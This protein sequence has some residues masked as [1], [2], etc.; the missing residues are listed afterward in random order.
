MTQYHIPGREKGK[1]LPDLFLLAKT[2][3]Q[4]CD[5][6]K[7]W[8]LRGLVLCR[9]NGNVMCRMLA[10]RKQ[11]RG[12]LWVMNCFRERLHGRIAVPVGRSP[13]S[14][15]YAVADNTA[16]GCFSEA[17]DVGLAPHS[18]HCGWWR[19]SWNILAVLLPIY[20]HAT[21]RRGV[22]MMTAYCAC[23]IACL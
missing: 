23:P 5:W 15:C 4:V 20:R 12:Y 18:S 1:R 8:H 6:S 22:W 9:G 16:I 7:R 21:C 17:Y 3:D 19:P 10:F 13:L 14:P 11:C 2:S